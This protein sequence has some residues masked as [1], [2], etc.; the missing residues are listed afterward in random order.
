VKFLTLGCAVC[1]GNAISAITG[2]AKSVPA[3]PTGTLMAAGVRSALGDFAIGAPAGVAGL[4]VWIGCVMDVTACYARRTR[5]WPAQSQTPIAGATFNNPICGDRIA[6]SGQVVRSLTK[7]R[8][9]ESNDAARLWFSAGSFARTDKKDTCLCVEKHPG[10][11]SRG[12]FIDLA[13]HL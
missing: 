1:T 6:I 3:T 2:G 13:R 11:F 7:S 5:R 8:D 10:D 9:P 4:L 12:F